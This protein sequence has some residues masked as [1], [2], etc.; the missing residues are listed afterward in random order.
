MR[1]GFVAFYALIVLFIAG[2]Y[3][4]GL[5][6]STID[7]NL[8]TR[9]HEFEIQSRLAGEAGLEI[10]RQLATTTMDRFGSCSIDLSEPGLAI[11]NR[12]RR[13]ISSFTVHYSTTQALA[14]YSY[15]SVTAV[16]SHQAGTFVATLSTRHFSNVVNVHTRMFNASYSHAEFPV[17]SWKKPLGG[18]DDDVGRAVRLESSGTTVLLGHTNSADGMFTGRPAINGTDALI[19]RMNASDVTDIG[20][21]GGTQDDGFHA[22]RT[23]LDGGHILVGYTCSDDGDVLINQR[24]V[25][26]GNQ[27][28]WAVKL[29]AT[30]TMEWNTCIG[31]S[32]NE[33][34]YS[35]ALASDGGYILAGFTDSNDGDVSGKHNGAGNM[36]G[37]LVHL[38]S[39]GAFLG[40]SN[41]VGGSRDEIFHSIKETLDGGFILAG[42][43]NSN[44]GD[45]SGAGYHNIV[46]N[47]ADV[48]L[49]KIRDDISLQWPSTKCFGGFAA[50]QASDVVILP[51]G[52]FLVVGAA[53]S[54]TG[55]VS[56]NHNAATSDG[57]LIKTNQAGTLQWQK[58]LGGWN[59]DYLRTVKPTRDGGIIL[60]G[61][62]FSNDGDVHGNN[63]GGDA[64]LVKLDADGNYLWDRCFGGSSEDAFLSLQETF[65]NGFILTGRTKSNNGD[66]IGFSGGAGSDIWTIKTDGEGNIQP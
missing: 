53:N 61:Q 18:T 48:W 10:C 46:G 28:M 5:Q 51:D 16:L 17:L 55:D 30:G 33:C 44:N 12:Q 57:W 34:A 3:F 63:G 9:Y 38:A 32:L 15:A 54:T 41:C 22:G 26:G 39:S 23:T 65:D 35:V 60:A 64:W 37:W 4:S 62:T 24:H 50:D 36:D 13:Y 20:Y 47:P 2:F 40:L 29:S 58:C 52:G 59:H 42:E 31:G 8:G 56:G 19:I 7:Q 14:S 45:V 25:R 49:V 21:Y 6:F 66:V 1:R 27:D 11:D 43:T